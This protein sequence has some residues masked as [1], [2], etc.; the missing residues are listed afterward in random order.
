MLCFKAA[1]EVSRTFFSRNPE[2]LVCTFPQ[3]TE[4]EIHKKER[5]IGKT[6]RFLVHKILNKRVK[7]DLIADRQ[8]HRSLGT[9]LNTTIQ[10]ISVRNTRNFVQAAKQSSKISITR[11]PH[12]RPRTMREMT[13][14]LR[15]VKNKKIELL[16]FENSRLRVLTAAHELKPICQLPTSIF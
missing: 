9:D 2:K 12:L 6:E 5:R 13:Y 16:N 4:S 1:V 7:L 3:F 14:T 15:K 10:V 11:N 8:H